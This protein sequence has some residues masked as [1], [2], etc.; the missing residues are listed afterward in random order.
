MLESCKLSGGVYSAQ[1]EEAVYSAFANMIQR[2]NQ[3]GMRKF[4]NAF[5]LELTYRL[6]D[7]AIKPTD[8]EKQDIIMPVLTYINANYNKQLSLEELAQKSGYSKS[9][10]SHIFSEVMHTTPVKY[11]N[12]IRLRA[13]SE[14]LTATSLSVTEIALSCGFSDPLYFSRL[15]KKRFGIPP[16]DYRNK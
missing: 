10:F 12:E 5:F 14:M 4:A 3:P 15:F 16:S 9:R 8:T 6:S 2:F 1:P 7:A 13:A 11:Q